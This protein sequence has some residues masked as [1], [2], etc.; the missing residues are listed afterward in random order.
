[1]PANYILGDDPIVLLGSVA[2]HKG[3]Q[4][5]HQL[6][7]SY[8]NDHSLKFYLDAIGNICAEHIL[9]LENYRWTGFRWIRIK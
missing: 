5:Y 3:P 7:N 8:K 2:G 9:H 6:P 1:M 4:A